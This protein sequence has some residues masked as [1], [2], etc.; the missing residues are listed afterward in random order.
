MRLDSRRGRKNV[1]IQKSCTVSWKAFGLL[2]K[3]Y[4]KAL[5]RE[6][7]HPQVQGKAGRARFESGVEVGSKPKKA[8]AEQSS[9][10]SGPL[11]QIPAVHLLH[12]ARVPLWSQ[13]WTFALLLPLAM[14]KGV[15]HLL[16]H[17][18]LHLLQPQFNQL[19]QL[20]V[21]QMLSHHLRFQTLPKA[22]Q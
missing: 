14:N 8:R 3:L 19:P 9:L 13:T 12:L 11:W 20:Q 5:T 10:E 17:Q 7:L 22:P 4:Q 15:H 21:R 6:A 18:M 2:R 16:S 1:M